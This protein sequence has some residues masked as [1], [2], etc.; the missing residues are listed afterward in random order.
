MG[1][2][3]P[4]SPFPTDLLSSLCCSVFRPFSFLCLDPNASVVVFAPLLGVLLFDGPSSSRV[5]PV[6]VNLCPTR[7]ILILLIVIGAGVCGS[8]SPCTAPLFHLQLE[9]SH[10]SGSSVFFFLSGR[11]IRA[12][13]LCAKFALFLGVASS[14]VFV[15]SSTSF[16][17]GHGL[18]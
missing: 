10:S 9:H 15:S 5:F 14:C 12:L 4:C 3:V 18:Q 11:M 6:L 13:N 17:F 1:L 16:L 7:P 2:D 8:F